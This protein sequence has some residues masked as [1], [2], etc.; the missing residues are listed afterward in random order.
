MVVGLRVRYEAKSARRAHW[1]RFV[2]VVDVDSIARA[3]ADDRFDEVAEIA[4]ADRG[5]GEAGRRDALEQVLEDRTLAE[6]QE[7]LGQD[8]GVRQESCSE[9]SGKDECTSHAASQP[10][11]LM[12]ASMPERK[13][14]RLVSGPPRIQE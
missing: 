1:A 7:R 14:D 10:P 4:E 12:Q 5:P 13:R 9:A 6:W 8:G 11:I 2:G 3:V